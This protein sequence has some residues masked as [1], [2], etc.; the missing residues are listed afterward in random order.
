MLIVALMSA[1]VSA[2][3]ALSVQA[4]IVNVLSKETIDEEE[5]KKE[6]QKMYEARIR[7]TQ[8]LRHRATTASLEL[9]ERAEGGGSSDNDLK[10]LQTELTAHY[11]YLK[12]RGASA[13]EFQGDS[14]L[15]PLSSADSFSL[16]IAGALLWARRVRTDRSSRVF[17]TVWLKPS[18]KDQGQRS[19]TKLRRQIFWKSCRMWGQRCFGSAEGF[20]FSPLE[21]TTT[22]RW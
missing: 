10:N 22:N 19:G 20:R 5:L 11:Q 13:K 15:C 18:P 7:R 8:S 9:V 4:L 3:F 6:N 16:Q 2:P 17:Y 12:T 21:R 1:I 14:V